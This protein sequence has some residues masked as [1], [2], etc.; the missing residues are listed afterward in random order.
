M[1]DDQEKEASD[2]CDLIMRLARAYVAV[3]VPPLMVPVYIRQPTIP[4]L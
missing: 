1:L 4:A 2:E 3:V